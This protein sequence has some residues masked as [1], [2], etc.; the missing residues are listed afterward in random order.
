MKP[1]MDLDELLFRYAEQKR[2]TDVLSSEEQAMVE[3]ALRTNPDAQRT[4]Q[5]IQASLTWMK[6]VRK[7]APPDSLASRCL[8]TRTQRTT[9]GWFSVPVLSVSTV[10]AAVFVTGLWLGNLTSAPPVQPEIEVFEVLLKQQSILTEDLRALYEAR[11]PEDDAAWRMH[12]EALTQTTDAIHARYTAH[13]GDPIM[14]TR[15]SSVIQNNIR[16]LSLMI[17]TVEEADS[18][19]GTQIWKRDT[20]N[21]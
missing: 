11:Y 17:S 7:P 6:A 3:Q 12:L 18:A 13:R 4:Y 14:E 16:M 15:L 19:S 9:P 21:L 5:E 1:S 10:L 8:Q 2:G 20:T